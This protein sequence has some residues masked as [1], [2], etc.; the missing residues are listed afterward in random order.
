[1]PPSCQCLAYRFTAAGALLRSAHRLLLHHGL[2]ALEPDPGQ[3][4]V[5]ELPVASIQHVLAQHPATETDSVEVFNHNHISGITK[6]VSR[7]EVKVLAGV[8]NLFV[9]PC[10]LEPWKRDTPPV[11]LGRLFFL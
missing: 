2:A 7:L 3:H 6:L 1:M 9:H 10:H 4:R 8:G 5:K 11:L